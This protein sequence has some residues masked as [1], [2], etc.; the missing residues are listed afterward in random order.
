MADFV[1]SVFVSSWLYWLYVEETVRGASPPERS[2]T[3]WEVTSPSA[4]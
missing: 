3:V 4:S 2:A 1:A